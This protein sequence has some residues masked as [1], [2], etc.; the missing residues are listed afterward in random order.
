MTTAT[1]T[2]VARNGHRDRSSPVAE[3]AVG[4]GAQA[5]QALLH[6]RKAASAGGPP[7]LLGSAHPSGRADRQLSAFGFGAG[8]EADCGQGLKKGFGIDE[9]AH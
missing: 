9:R 6:E 7:V 5:R 8:F 4:L 2:F 1:G 3:H